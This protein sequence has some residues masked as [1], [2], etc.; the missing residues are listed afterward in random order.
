MSSH[1]DCS[2]SSLERRDGCSASCFEESK[3]VSKDDK[4]SRRGTRLHALM[5]YRLRGR[6]NLDNLN[7]DE[8]TAVLDLLR[9]GREQNLINAE[10]HASLE[11]RLTAPG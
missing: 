7:E 11:E 5:V 2:P 1:S 10:E 3:L 4:D 8:R 9:R 6:L